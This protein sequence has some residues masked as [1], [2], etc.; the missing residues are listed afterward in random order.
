MDSYM[1]VSQGVVAIQQF[2]DLILSSK[3]EGN[4]FYFYCS[5]T[6]LEVFVK[7]D[8]IIRFRFAP[9]GKFMRDF[10]YSGAPEYQEEINLLDMVESE[11]Q[12][13]VITKYLECIITKKGMHVSILDKN[14]M[15]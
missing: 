10:S 13:I 5:E 4:K 14:G 9:E 1:N 11:D 8:K 12:Y 7:S 6:T 3:R 2:P 15:V